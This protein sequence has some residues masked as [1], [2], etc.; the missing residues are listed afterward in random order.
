MIARYEHID[1]S[2][3]GETIKTLEEIVNF[4]DVSEEGIKIREKAIYRLA[5]IYS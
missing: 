2:N 5:D 3:L 1:D 4:D